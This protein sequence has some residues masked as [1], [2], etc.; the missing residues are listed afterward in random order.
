M[1]IFNSTTITVA[2]A[3]R[4]PFANHSFSEDLDSMWSIVQT[5]QLNLDESFLINLNSIRR[6]GDGDDF[7]HL[8]AKDQSGI[9]TT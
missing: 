8:Q 2:L 5:N 9:I 3:S 7:W 4:G 1:K 6:P